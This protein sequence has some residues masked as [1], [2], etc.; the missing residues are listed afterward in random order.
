MKLNKNDEKLLEFCLSG[1]QSVS[2]IARHLDI[3]PKNVS[4]RLQKLIKL[5]L[6]SAVSEGKGKPTF[7]RSYHA[8]KKIVKEIINHILEGQ[9]Q[10]CA[11]QEAGIYAIFEE[12]GYDFFE[13]MKAL[14][15]LKFNSYLALVVTD[16]GREFLKEKIEKEAG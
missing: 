15:T 14:N 13:I 4:V 11:I 7:V 2:Q 1:S 6:I 9:K 3:A 5:K 10:S 16:E 12:K 8:D